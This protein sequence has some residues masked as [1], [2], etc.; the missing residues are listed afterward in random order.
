MIGRNI[1]IGLLIFLGFSA[2]GGG[3]Y[4]IVSPSGE[5]IGMTLSLLDKSPFSD[6]LIPGIILLTILGIAPLLIVIGLIKKPASNSAE[7][8][9]FFKDMHW[10]WSFAVYIA[11]ALIIW[12]QIE[13]M[14][15]RTYDSLQTFCS[16][17]GLAILFVLLLPQ[18]RNLYK[19]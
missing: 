15:I 13:V 8:I 2:I 18:V 6:F 14:F 9:N 4:L 19:K 17:L 16:F 7:R 10:T 5:L 11:F 12:I 1:L 3:I